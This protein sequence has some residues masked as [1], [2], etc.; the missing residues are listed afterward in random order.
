MKK[1]LLLLFFLVGSS[2]GAFSKVSVIPTDSA[3][4][5]FLRAYKFALQYSHVD[6]RFTNAT[7][8][9]LLFPKFGEY[10]IYW[11]AE[12]EGTGSFVYPDVLPKDFSNLTKFEYP[13]YEWRNSQHFSLQI[14]LNS[15]LVCIFQSE[16]KQNN[17]TVT[18]ASFYY[19]NLFDLTF[20][21]NMY[22]FANEKTIDS[23]GISGACRLLIIPPFRK[24]SDDDK[25]YID[26]I[27][28]EYPNIKRRFDEFLAR[29]GT[30]Y[31]EGNAVYFLEKLGYLEN[32]S[33]D[34]ANSY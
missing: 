21:D 19:K 10:S 5:D 29:G 18:W 15:Q 11:I 1:F 22:Y 33:V 16:M 26:K 13:Q 25:Y 34:F 2:I 20:Y 24:F 4:N 3:Q 8:D 12:G 6:Y 28:A 23:I 30:I 31:A 14:K 27:F 9:S 7:M 17:A 32:K